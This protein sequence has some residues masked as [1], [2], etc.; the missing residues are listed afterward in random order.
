[1][2]AT[3]R[4]ALCSDSLFLAGIALDLQKRSNIQVKTLDIASQQSRE[5]L[6]DYDPH[7]ILFDLAAIDPHFIFSILSQAPHVLVLGLDFSS[8]QVLMLSSQWCAGL[9]LGDL[10][11]M[12]EMP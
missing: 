6:K 12:I 5:C 10:A 3:R 1:M 2:P 11:H 8:K 7:A 4:V 9:T